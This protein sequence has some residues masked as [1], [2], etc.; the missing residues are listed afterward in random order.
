MSTAKVVKDVAFVVD[1]HVEY[2]N[3]QV[4]QYSIGIIV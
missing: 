3:L 1:A 2:P 4:V